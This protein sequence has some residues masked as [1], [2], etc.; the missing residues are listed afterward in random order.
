MIP[1]SRS[2]SQMFSVE[3]FNSA[4]NFRVMFFKTCCIQSVI[5]GAKCKATNAGA[6][7]SHHFMLDFHVV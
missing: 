7:L 4:M 1:F 2:Y 6:F 5:L 3:K